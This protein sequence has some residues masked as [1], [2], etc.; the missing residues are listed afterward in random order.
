M[1]HVHMNMV[2]LSVSICFSIFQNVFP[3]V[4]KEER[5]RVQC[6]TW[7]QWKKKGNVSV[8]IYTLYTIL[9][10]LNEDVGAGEHIRTWKWRRMC[11]IEGEGAVENE[12]VGEGGGVGES[13]YVGKSCKWRWKWRWIWMCR[14]GY[15]WRWGCEP[16][17][18]KNVG[19]A[20][21]PWLK[22]AKVKVVKMPPDAHRNLWQLKR[23]LGK[24][25]EYLYE[26][27]Y[28]GGISVYIYAREWA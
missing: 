25:R 3:F 22:W 21:S 23:K 1:N 27:A 26:R 15:R 17:F 18:S 10:K 7:Y 16:G 28:A 4:R 19:L 11:K 9:S 13:E 20:A 6:E 24:S 14:W 12:G 5:E 8:V 2:S